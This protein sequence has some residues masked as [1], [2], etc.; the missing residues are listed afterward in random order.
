MLYLFIVLARIMA[1]SSEPG[2]ALS[3][4]GMTHSSTSL[5]STLNGKYAAA[6]KLMSLRH[7][8]RE[9]LFFNLFEEIEVHTEELILALESENPVNS[10]LIE[11]VRCSK[12]EFDSHKNGWLRKFSDKNN[13]DSSSSIGTISNA[14]SRSSVRRRA[15]EAKRAS[16]KLELEQLSEREQ[17]LKELLSLKVEQEQRALELKTKHA[18]SE[19]RRR[20]EAAEVELN[21]W[22]EIDDDGHLSSR[23]APTSGQFD[24]NAKSDEQSCLHVSKPRGKPPLSF[25]TSTS[26]QTSLSSVPVCVSEPPSLTFSNQF[27]QSSHY[28][29]RFSFSDHNY[30]DFTLILPR[31]HKRFP[32]LNRQTFPSWLLSHTLFCHSKVWLQ[33][34][35]LSLNLNLLKLAILFL[36]RHPICRLQG[37]KI[38]L[39]NRILRFD[40]QLFGHKSLRTFLLRRARLL[41]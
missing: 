39:P 15:A 19:A 5:Q 21:V 35:I 36:K 22:S 8:D 37:L 20:L 12:E 32:N 25:I 11:N 16:A 7:P 13:C 24:I 6:E 28:V 10:D 3:D 2:G 17:E 14:S 38:I 23:L 33:S 18:K 27:P 9:R 31:C 1:A 40:H 26:L 4:L 29:T 30:P 41:K 34:L